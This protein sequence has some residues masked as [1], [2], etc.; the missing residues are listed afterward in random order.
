MNWSIL[1]LPLREHFRERFF[2]RR[3]HILNNL[4]SISRKRKLPQQERREERL[5]IARELHDTVLQGFLSASMQLCVVNDS[6]SADSP[7]KPAL[8]RALDLMRK[9]LDEARNALLGLRAPV[10]PDG[11]LEKALSEFRDDFAPR[12]RTSI[13]IVITGE[14]TSL[15]PTL[16]EQIFLI[17]REAL[18][19][20]LRHSRATEVEA[21]V[22]YLRRKLRVVV[23]D[24][25]IGIDPQLLRARQDSHWGLRGMRERAASIG[26]KFQLWTKP[27]AGTE[28]AISVPLRRP[29]TRPPAN[30]AGS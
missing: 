7:A 14:T 19:N 4:N 1:P 29:R 8:Q 15:D 30:S 18:L 27:G 20:A 24:N 23:R 6:L 2:Q 13:R 3:S 9:C 25:G 12:D 10:L 5:R 28:V 17:A 11:S 21:E 16:L 26:A 22:E